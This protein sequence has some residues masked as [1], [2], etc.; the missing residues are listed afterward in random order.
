MTDAHEDARL[1]TIR[2]M[3][4]LRR[5]P[6]RYPSAVH[7]AGIRNVCAAIE[8]SAGVCGR[9]PEST[10]SESVRHP[11]PRSRNSALEYLFAQDVGVSAVVGQLSQILQVHPA[12]RA[13]PRSVARHDGIK[14]QV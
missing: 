9:H 5:S 6:E 10:R 1:F 2:S 3:V 11:R 4:Q 7:P 12:K 14:W 13:R 8:R